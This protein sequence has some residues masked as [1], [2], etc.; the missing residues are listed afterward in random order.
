MSSD[1]QKPQHP[2]REHAA[3]VSYWLLF[4]LLPLG[5]FLAWRG[6]TTVSLVLLVPLFFVLVLAGEHGLRPWRRLWRLP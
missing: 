2:V 4:I 3:L 5:A 1:Q 6:M